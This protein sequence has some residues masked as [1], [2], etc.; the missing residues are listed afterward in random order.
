VSVE[1]VKQVS[2]TNRGGIA[3]DIGANHGVYTGEMLPFYSK[4]Y[5][6]EPHPDNIAIIKNR[7]FDVGNRLEIVPMAVSDM[8]GDCKLYLH[9]SQGQY[10]ISE[11]VANCKRWGHN[12]DNWIR[13]PCITID[14]FCEQNN[15]I[16]NFIKMDIEGAENYVWCGALHTLYHH[17]VKIVLELHHEVNLNKLEKWFNALDYYGHEPF[18]YD[19]NI[20][21][22]K[23]AKND[24]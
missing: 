21:I 2:S 15:V 23:R 16:P 5:A 17:D 9:V 8:S 24:Q 1:L 10:S 13:V 11:D 6:F 3:F 7:L 19:K 20:L 22:T 12:P 18:E 4:V 14:D